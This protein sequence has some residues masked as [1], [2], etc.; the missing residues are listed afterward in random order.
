MVEAFGCSA[1]DQIDNFIRDQVINNFYS[2][3]L[4]N[5]LLVEHNVGISYGSIW[6]SVGTYVNWISGWQYS[7]R[8]P[9]APVQAKE[10]F[11]EVIKVCHVET[12]DFM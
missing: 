1:W 7:C 4:C 6:T 3:R 11:I 12:E 2:K 10:T 5:K 8:L 9:Q